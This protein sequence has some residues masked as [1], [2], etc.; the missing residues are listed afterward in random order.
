MKD[1]F[2]PEAWARHR[3]TVLSVQILNSVAFE[4]LTGML[5]PPSPITPE[6]YAQYGLKFFASYAEG[7]DT[8]GAKNLAGLKSVG[9]IDVMGGVFLGVNVASA[10]N[11]GCTVC[12]R[13]LCDAM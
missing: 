11:V 12:R 4:A 9:E 3:A 10:R 5:A 1:P 8:D 13:M 7:V 6:T 2:K